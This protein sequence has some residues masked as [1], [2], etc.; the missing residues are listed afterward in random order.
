MNETSQEDAASSASALGAGYYSCRWLEGGLCFSI[1]ALRA[2]A[3][4]H[5]GRGELKLMDYAGGSLDFNVIRKAKDEI[6]RQNQHGGHLAYKGCPNL[7]F[8]RWF[9]RIGKFNWIGI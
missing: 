9:V 4:I 6:H 1:G 2:C 8:R 3:E 5:H 7:V